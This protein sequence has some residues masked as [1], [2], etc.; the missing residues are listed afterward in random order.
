MA[1]VIHMDFRLIPIIGR[2]GIDYGF[3]DKTIADVCEEQGI[4]RCFFLEI[5]NLY[6]NPNYISE[7]QNQDFDCDL[8]IQYMLKTHA[9]YRNRKIPEIEKIIEEMERKVSGK[10]RNNITLLKDFFYKYK[11][12]LEKHLSYEEPAIFA[13]AG[14]LKDALSKNIYE[15]ELIHKIKSNP[16]EEYPEHSNLKFKLS[17]LKNL[18]IRYLPPVLCKAS[19]QRLLIALFHLENDLD[20]HFKIEEKVLITQIK[21]LEKKI[22]E[23]YDNR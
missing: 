10:N 20:N 19:C 13:Y 9:Y 23:R 22:L 1:D 21:S 8:T 11:N 18:I 2:F 5:I 14:R 4:N 7:K 15:Q 16:L 6:H 17:D 12:E 3:Q